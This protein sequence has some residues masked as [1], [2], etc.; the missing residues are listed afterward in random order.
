MAKALGVNRST[1]YR[2]LN[3]NGGKRGGYDNQRAQAKAN[4]RRQRL[5]LPRTYTVENRRI[6]HD[7]LQKRWSP[8]QIAGWLL[9]EKGIKVSH[10]TIYADI[11]ADKQAGGDLWKYCRH[12][13]KHRRRPVGG[14]IPIPERV[15]IEER[16]KE[17][18]GKRFGDFE[19]DTIIGKDGK[20]AI[21]TI[22]ERLTNY[23]MAEKLPKGKD[24]DGLAKAVIRLLTPFIGHIRSIT[25]DNGSEFAAHKTI[26]KRLKTTV[27]FAHPYS[28]WEKGAIEN[29]NKLLRQY[30][31]KKADFEDFKQQDI[32]TFQKEINERPREKLNFATPKNEFYSHFWNCCTSYLNLPLKKR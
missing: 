9:K 6:V 1:I 14:S 16:P 29:F 23:S 32:M 26:A 19:M 21:L 20:G 10:E 15:G 17:A 30:I 27:Y 7:L 5:H 11:R 4:L 12:S 2:E 13:M 22:T 31:P 8:R 3:R 18:D 24:A 28:A 25:T